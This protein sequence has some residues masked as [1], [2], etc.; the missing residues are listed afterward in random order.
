MPWNYTTGSYRSLLIQAWFRYEIKVGV[1]NRHKQTR[2]NLT[3]SIWLTSIC[4][5]AYTSSVGPCWASLSFKMEQRMEC[6][7]CCIQQRVPVPP[8]NPY[9]VR[10]C[11]AM[12][13]SRCQ[14]CCSC[15]VHECP[16]DECIDRSCDD[17]TATR[18]HAAT[19]HFLHGHQLPR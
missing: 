15:H 16:N 17:C 11:V 5:I 2:T 8:T 14:Q 4:C 1:V 6:S 9:V 13:P 12:L 19:M 18:I 7:V 10:F 3:G